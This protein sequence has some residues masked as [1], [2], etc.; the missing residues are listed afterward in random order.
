VLLGYKWGK[1]PWRTELDRVMAGMNIGMEKLYSVFG[2]HLCRALEGR[3]LVSEV[4]RWLLSIEPGQPFYADYQVP[5]EASGIGLSEGAR[6]AVGHWIKIKDRNISHYQVI[7]PST[8]NCSPKDDKGNPGPLEQA[9]LG[10]KIK[11]EESPVE[12]TRIVRSFDPCLACSVQLVD[13]KRLKGKKL[14]L[15]V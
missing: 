13:K 14:D 9:L 5:Q 8:W 15:W 3:V 10:T 11:N 6:G 12:I 1:E 2:R 4:E 7:A